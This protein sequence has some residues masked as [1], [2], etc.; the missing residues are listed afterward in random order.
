MK[1]L[2]LWIVAVMVCFGI[3]PSVAQDAEVNKIKFTVNVSPAEAVKCTVQGEEY[4]LTDGANVFELPEDTSIVFVGNS[5]W[6]ITSVT[7]KSGQAPSGFYGS[8]WYLYANSSS[9]DQEYTI[10]VI[11]INDLRTSQFTINVDDPSL[12]TAML[13]GYYTTLNLQPGE[14]IVK[15]DPKVENYLTLLPVNAAVPFY[16]VKMDGIEIAPQG[17]SYSI[18][19]RNNSVIDVIAILPDEDRTVNFS[20]APGAENAISI[21]VN[22][23]DMP[24]F[25]GQSLVV[26]L[27]DV[28]TINGNTASYKFNAV[29]ING[30]AI[31]FY[32]SHTFAVMKNSDIYIDARPYGN[33]S[34]S[35]IINNPELI[36]IMG[37][38]ET[39]NLIA[40]TNT[41]QLPENNANITWN[42]DPMAVL[43]S[44]RVNDN[45]PLPSYQSNYA[46]SAGDVIAFDVVAKV[47]DQEAIVWIDN[48]A[49]KACSTYFEMSSP[50]DRSV[51][52]TLENGYNI[53]NY[54]QAMNPFAIS[55]SGYSEENP[56]ISLTGKVYLNDILQQSPYGDTST[57]YSID[58]ANGDVLKLFMDSDPIM[59]NVTFDLADG[60]EANVVKDVITAV[61]NPAAGFNC[62]AGTQVVV[63][64]KDLAVSVNGTAIE[65]EKNEE[66]AETYT[67]IVNDPTTA[68]TVAAAGGSG[69]ASIA[70][71][72]DT[73]VYNMQ[74]VKV[75]NKADLKTLTPGLYI[76][77][78]KKVVISD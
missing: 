78:G 55:W 46:L 40:G 1:N 25:N 74:G 44:V 48:V 18:Q 26:K 73:A 4:P 2:Y 60:I 62:F 22:D 51:H 30:E 20:Y 5:P 52:F 24:D 47:F 63:A 17:N 68:V 72:A 36:S 32:G 23:Q 38:G 50:S 10:E 59:C 41:I 35:I 64:G 6:M 75:G 33:I 29:K 69:V 67:F 16:S 11:N 65:S 8:D 61:E 70:A 28:L 39:L 45:E 56:E 77:A 37:N 76:V 3:L 19:L 71:E 58:I 43:N 42:V 14:N 34:A 21:K 31:N 66:G 49:G 15:Y 7:D 27:G 13:T 53:L 12:V 57:Y 9:Q 54:Y